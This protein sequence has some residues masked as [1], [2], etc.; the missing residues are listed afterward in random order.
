MWFG[1]HRA[2]GHSSLET[3]TDILIMGILTINFITFY[4]IHFNWSMMA[5]QPL[6]A[7]EVR[8]QFARIGSTM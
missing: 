8:A 5:Y 3:I 1:Q 6:W 4:L 2:Q 7:H